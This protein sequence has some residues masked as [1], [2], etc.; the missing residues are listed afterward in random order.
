[1]EQ[2]AFVQ[3]SDTEVKV[4]TSHGWETLIEIEH[5]DWDYMN[6]IATTLKRI[7]RHAWSCNRNHV[8]KHTG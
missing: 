5:S 8:V 4:R 1:M 6:D 2:E 3:W 7:P